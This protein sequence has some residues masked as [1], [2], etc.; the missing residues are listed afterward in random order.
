MWHPLSGG[1]LEWP[2]LPLAALCTEEAL[3]LGGGAEK[4]CSLGTCALGRGKGA[5]TPRR[6]RLVTKDTLLSREALGQ[7]LEASASG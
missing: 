4:R 2:P 3:S 7:Q 5:V 1:T 6:L